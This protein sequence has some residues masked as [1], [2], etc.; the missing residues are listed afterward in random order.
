MR[1][2][3]ILLLGLILGTVAC[4]ADDT[5]NSGDSPTTP[6]PTYVGAPGVTI[7]QVAIYQGVKRIL[8]D[9]GGTPPPTVGLVVGRDTLIRVHYTTAPENIGQPVIG[10]LHIGGSDAY[11]DPFEAPA[12]LFAQSIEP[13]MNTTVNFIVPGDAITELLSYTVSIVQEGDPSA[14]DNPTAHH[15][16]PDIA[17]AVHVEAPRNV[18]RVVFVPFQYNADGSGRLP[19]IVEQADDYKNR[20]KQLYPVSDVEVVVREPVPWSDPI[21]PSGQGWEEVGFQLFQIRS[22]EKPGPDWYYYGIFNPTATIQQFCG[23]GCL[24]GV[25]LLN[26]QPPDVGN[27]A[28]RLGLGVGFPESGPDTT[29]HELGH[30]HGREHAPCGFGLDPS[31][32]DAG[33]PHDNGGIGHWG[34]D[35]V[36]QTLIDPAI[37]SDIMGYCDDQW[38]SDHTFNALI[39][40]GTAV[41]L[42]MKK[43]P[44]P[45]DKLPVDTVTADKVRY[46]LINID[47][48]GADWSRS[49]DAT[50]LTT[51]A[52]VALTVRST[53]GDAT[54]LQGHF[55]RWDHMPGGWLLFPKPA[56]EPARAEVVMNGETIVV[57]RTR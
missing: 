12:T 41:N 23:G 25:T 4:G 38:V 28:L 29:A 43:Q 26:N 8:F 36:N 7:Q 18:F 20:L 27:E 2:R 52:T 15:P 53:G 50:A 34:W 33:Y 55:F 17:E 49:I 9:R 22:A 47:A 56:F 51:D 37:Y 24:L 6:E 42:P 57:H 1:Q 46:E 54:E 21:L 3:E 13:D 5:T 40:R 16:G 39:S 31:S 44:P 48:H 19:D 10:R 32:I 30:A 11:T 45:L 14:G 35:I